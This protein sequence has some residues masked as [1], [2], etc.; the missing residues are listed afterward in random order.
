[1]YVKYNRIKRFATFE[2]AEQKIS[3]QSCFTLFRVH[4]HMTQYDSKKRYQYRPIP[5]DH[6]NNSHFIE[7]SEA[8]RC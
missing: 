3:L 5:A 8:T 4:Y 2:Q 6:A 7:Y 1:M